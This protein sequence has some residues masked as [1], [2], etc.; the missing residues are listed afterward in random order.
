LSI[1]IVELLVEGY[2]EKKDDQ[3][4]RFMRM[5]A[6]YLTS[7]SG[8]TSHEIVEKV[9]YSDNNLKSK[10]MSIFDEIEQKA[11]QETREEVWKEAREE[12]QKDK[13]RTI[14]RSWENGISISM[15]SNITGL[16]I[17]DIEKVIAE[18]ES[19]N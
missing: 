11:K 3:T 13:N 9:N 5:S 19:K 12:A 15:I 16:S 17:A 2:D 10:V 18:H 4:R 8:M 14:I 7:I 1:H 6:V